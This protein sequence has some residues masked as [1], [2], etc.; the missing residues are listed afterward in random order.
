MTFQKHSGRPNSAI[1]TLPRRLNLVHR[2]QNGNENAFS[3]SPYRA[4]GVQ[5]AVRF[6]IT[7]RRPA[8]R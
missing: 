6:Q 7:Y 2:V 1:W 8:V 5:Y 3:I 4:C